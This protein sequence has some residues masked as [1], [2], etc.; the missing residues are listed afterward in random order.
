MNPLDFAQERRESTASWQ[1]ADPTEA[2]I[3]RIAWDTW[4]VTLPDSED[5][6]EVTLH[7]DHGA[8]IGECELR[9][10]DDRCPAR[11]Y[12]DA[13]KPCAHLCTILKATLF[14]DP[15]IRGSSIEVFDVSDVGMASADTHIE[16]AMAGDRD[17]VATDGG[18]EVRQ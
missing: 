11:K 18:P 16:S 6:H 3:E 14:N 9:H 5:C 15:D 8:L 12:N 10:E 4:L 7:R 17:P 2:L 13:D 1:R